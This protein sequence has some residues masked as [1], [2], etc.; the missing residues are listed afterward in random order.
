MSDDG[1]CDCSGALTWS[2]EFGGARVTERARIRL[3]SIDPSLSRVSIGGF[4]IRETL[5]ALER[6][7]PRYAESRR[8]LRA[9]ARAS[10]KF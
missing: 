1:E 5:R 10:M 4:D 6:T 2:G 8:V 9:R 3:I 7:W